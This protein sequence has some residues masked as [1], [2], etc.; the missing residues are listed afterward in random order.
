MMYKLRCQKMLKVHAS[1]EHFNSCKTLQSN[2]KHTHCATNFHKRMY[3]ELLATKK[4]KYAWTHTCSLFEAVQNFHY[5]FKI[6]KW[7]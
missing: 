2:F 1:P 4:I 6:E 5:V 3:V 7:L